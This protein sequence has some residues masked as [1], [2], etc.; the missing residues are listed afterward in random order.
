MNNYSQS[1]KENLKNLSEQVKD[2]LSRVVRLEGQNNLSQ[3]GTLQIKD[4]PMEDNSEHGSELS[5]EIH[6]ETIESR[7]GEVGMAW[8]GNIVLLFGIIFLLQLL[9]N[10]GFEIASALAGFVAVGGVYFLGHGLKNQYHLMSKLFTYNG[11]LLLFFVIMRLHFISSG[12]VITSKPLGLLLVLITIITLLYISFRDRSQVLAAIVLVMAVV[13][14]IFSNSTHVMLTLMI[15]IAILSVFLSIKFGWWDILILS[16]FL[17]YSTYLMWM[18][19]NPFINHSLEAV[20][21]HQFSHLYLF[22]FAF[23][24]SIPALLKANEKFN[25]QRLNSIIIING[26]GFSLTTSFVILTFFSENYVLLL[27]LIS[28]FCVI[29]SI[30]LQWKGDWKIASALYALYGFVVLSITVSII[31]KFP[32]AFLLL[33]IQSL[34]V[35]SMALWFRSR[36]IVIMNVVLFIGLLIAYLAFNESINIVNIAFA[37]VALITARIMNWKK[38]R[39]EIRTELIRNI[40]LFSGFIMTLIS[41]YKVVPAKFVTLSWTL[42]ALL[43]FILSILLSNVKYRWLAI[44]TMIV[45]AIHLF[46]FDLKNISIGYRIVALLFLA[47]ISLG[48]SIFYARRMKIKNSESEKEKN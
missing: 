29:Y 38:K 2:L 45:T 46:L 31:Y 13:L 10:Q 7:I 37:V 42:S 44:T 21:N 41:L 14:G 30:I 48:I 35:V 40:Y 19:N 23:I 25:T 20:S 8:L 12:E 6:N 5:N 36:F 15:A 32:L 39:L 34:L 28:A 17:V 11:H 33:S 16:I 43:F 4:D 3:S 24:Y 47:I 22:G 27:G 26:I 9:N 1:D 18:L